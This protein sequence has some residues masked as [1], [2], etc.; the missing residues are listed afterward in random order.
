[1]SD[2][3]GKIISLTEVIESKVIKEKELEF[4]REQ[5]VEIQRKIGFLELD[6][7]LTKQIIGLIEK[8]SIVSIDNSVPLIG[9]DPDADV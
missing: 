2:E 9:V 1:M 6:L 3:E 5:L 7:N 8:E 4:Y